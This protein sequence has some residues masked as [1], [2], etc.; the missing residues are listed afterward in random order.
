MTIHILLSNL[1]YPDDPT[2]LKKLNL[3][4]STWVEI[5]S[6]RLEASLPIESELRK[7]IEGI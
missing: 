2:N 5:V 3:I 4:A 7:L 6:C 1:S